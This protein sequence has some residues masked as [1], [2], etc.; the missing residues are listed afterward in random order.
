MKKNVGSIDK[1]VRMIIAVVIVTLSY[2]EI[3]NGTL[4]IILLVFALILVVTS[5]MNFCP[6][7]ALLGK[8]S[9]KKND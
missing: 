6:V 2:F 9:A 4:S 5:F 1:V 8:S 7:F 3:I